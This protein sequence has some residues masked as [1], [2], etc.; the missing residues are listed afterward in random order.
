MI[1]RL[2]R[3]AAALLLVAVA[4]PA[5]AHHGSASVG[6][7]GNEGPGAA[8]DTA[9]PL[10]LGQGTAFALLRSER[11]SFQQREGFTDQRSHGQVGARATLGA[12]SVGLSVKRA[13]ARKL[14]E[15]ADQQGSEGLEA[16]RAAL[17][18]SYSTRF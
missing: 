15:G 4:L 8:L 16:Y 18:V 10:P 9:S 2:A 12:L 17:A 1:A 3:A 14:N 11:A 6:G 7:L 13:L 5:P